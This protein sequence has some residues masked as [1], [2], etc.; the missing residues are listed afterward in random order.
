MK[1]Q[2]RQALG[3]L[4]SGSIALALSA[5]SYANVT[6]SNE[7][8]RVAV[9]GLNGRGKDHIKGF[10]DRV[11]AVCDCDMNVLNAVA[12]PLNVAK[13]QD[14][15]KLLD[16]TDIDAVS[17]ATPNH[18]HSLIAIRALEAGKHVYVEK[19]VSHNV[20]EG[21]QLAIAAG[22]YGRVC[23]CGTQSRS[24][25]SLKQAVEFVRSGKLGKIQY[26]I[27][28]C[29]KPRLSIGRTSEPLVIPAH[30][31]FPLWCGPAP[32]RP[33]YRPRL[34]YDWHWDFNTGNGDMGNQGIHQ[35]DIARWFLGESQL[36]PRVIS[37][38]GRLGYADGGNT[39]NT[40]VV[41]HAYEQAPLVFETRG[42]PAAQ[43]FQSDRKEWEG[44]MDRFRGSRVGV[45]VQCEQG[46]VL[47]PNYTSAEAFDGSGQSIQKWE[48][49]SD[50]S[51][52]QNFLTAAEANDP[53][54]LNAPVLEGHL[55]SALCHTGGVSH[56]VGQLG[57]LTEVQRAAQA[58]PV[59]ADA[60][61]RMLVHLRANGV[62]LD[63]QPQL[64]VGADLS[65]DPERE[66]FVN[67][68]AGNA[69]LRRSGSAPFQIPDLESTASSALNSR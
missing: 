64:V 15:R 14:F 53:G 3:M 46:H 8:L 7:R 30:I 32:E 13:F 39:P 38:G 2:R 1:I 58:H 31:D 12:E 67:N 34:H 56:Q 25:P 17:I 16:Q 60:V 45:I 40:Q 61:E 48:G 24:S 20:W 41:L 54:Q 4:A 50:E 57:T 11:V 22:K 49:G 69:L 43:N 19:P 27:G 23:Q 37:I 68:E 9:I 29:Y 47:I 65:M 28:T 18:T 51:H 21:R 52:Y 6:G 63:G 66:K 44:N 33:I 62:D 26:A 5:K 36:S 42:L 59:F 55:S 35:M 10:G